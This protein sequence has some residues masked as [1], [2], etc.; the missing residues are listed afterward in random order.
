MPDYTI[1]L[2]LRRSGLHACINWLIPHFHGRVRLVNDPAFNLPPRLDDFT[3][4]T[5]DYEV[6]AQR[7]M[8]LFTLSQLIR[9]T[10]DFNYAVSR[11]WKRPWSG[12]SRR[13]LTR[14]WIDRLRE[15]TVPLPA[16]CARD[17]TPVRHEIILF[18]NLTPVACARDL[19]A[20]LEAYHTAHGRSEPIGR[21]RLILVLRSPWNGLASSLKNPQVS[22]PRVILPAAHHAAWLEFAREHA[23]TTQHLATTGCEVLPFIYDRW[24]RSIDYR[25]T[26]AER[27]GV[28][29]TD[30]GLEVVAEQG[31]GSSFDGVPTQLTGQALDVTARWR[32]F[33]QHP[34]MH[35][36]LADPEVRSLCEKI[37]GQPAPVAT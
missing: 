34:L 14:F 11:S 13:V 20:W 29:F 21:V 7:V 6:D 31:G 4:R 1:V 8:P 32:H 25:R 30:Y 19:R 22:P 5:L 27:L 35:A 15:V 17:R 10:A 2:G 23:G 18:E 36:L 16:F 26:L 33:A 28:A 37:F 9:K 12:L 24:A 3:T